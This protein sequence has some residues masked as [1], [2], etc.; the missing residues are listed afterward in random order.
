[1]P[2]NQLAR[3]LPKARVAHVSPGRLRLRIVEKRGD[4]AYFE[5]VESALGS[6][7]DFAA[8][9]VQ[10]TT[11]SLLM[12]GKNATIPGAADFG[13]KND[14]FDLKEQSAHPDQLIWD[15]AAPVQ[16]FSGHIRR[17]SGDT[18]DLSSG[19]FFGLLLFGL[20][21][22]LRGN[23]KTPPWYTAFWYAAGIY[24]KSLLDRVGGQD[25]SKSTDDA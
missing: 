15:T 21:E 23:W 16:A 13:R 4:R 7:P 12:V 9:Q 8:A 3:M 10:V 19:L 20:F 11:G 17:F 24:S 2:V 22:L 14:L 1:M 18:L 6:Q 5:K 25:A